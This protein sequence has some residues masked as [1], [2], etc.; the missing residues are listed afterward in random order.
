ME[1]FSPKHVP[2]LNGDGCRVGGEY[3]VTKKSRTILRFE[4]I[5]IGWRSRGGNL[6]VRCI[7]SFLADKSG[8]AAAE[9]A[10]MLGILG[11][12]IATAAL[13]LGG[14]ISSAYSN[15]ASVITGFSF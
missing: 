11:T 12:A 1:H 14:D 2:G 4:R 3:A 6:T 7:V 13:A 10:V 8:A 9:Y 15:A 5:A